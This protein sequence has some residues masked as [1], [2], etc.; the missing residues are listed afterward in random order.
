MSALEE[1]VKEKSPTEQNRMLL[2]AIWHNP[3]SKRPQSERN[4]LGIFNRVTHQPIFLCPRSLYKFKRI[5]AYFTL[6]K[7]E[8]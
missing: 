7:V 8:P 1:C 3:V 2:V 6:I 4:V 5:T